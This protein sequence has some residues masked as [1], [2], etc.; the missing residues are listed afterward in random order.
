M[1]SEELADAEIWVEREQT[2]MDEHMTHDELVKLAVEWL[3]RQH[4]VV[5]SE[6]ASGIEEADA[7]GFKPWGTTLIECKASRSDF[8]ADRHKPFR[9]NQ[10]SGMGSTRYYL[11]PKGVVLD[12]DELPPRWGLIEYRNGRYCMVHAPIV[13]PV[14]DK[15]V[16]S[17]MG[18]LISL[19]RR[20]GRAEP[21]KCVSVKI[22]TH[23]TKNRTTAH[24]EE[25][26][27]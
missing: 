8:M 2:K 15:D 13:Y 18:L 1:V 26:G 25:G 3:K 20:M 11:C 6:M 7:I 10:K 27:N 22:Y 21:E 19:I 23:E 16:Q 17:E 14:S 5:I 9:I 24:I 12:V 4:A